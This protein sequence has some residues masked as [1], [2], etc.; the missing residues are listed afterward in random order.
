[1]NG[2]DGTGSNM[3]MLWASLSFKA[4]TFEG[5]HWSL[6]FFLVRNLSEQNLE[7]ATSFIWSCVSREISW[8]LAFWQFWLRSFQVAMIFLSFFDGF[9]ISCRDMGTLTHQLHPN[10][11]WEDFALT[12]QLHP[13]QDWDDFALTHQLHPNQDWEDFA[14]RIFQK[15]GQ[16]SCF[17]FLNT[18]LPR[19]YWEH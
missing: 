15:Q 4:P 14:L 6:T 12:H 16:F 7:R 3:S 13:N 5:S 8:L 17:D 2:L 18:C 19:R 9:F 10:Q 1:M 11:D